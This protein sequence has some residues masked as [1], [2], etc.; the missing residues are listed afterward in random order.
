MFGGGSQFLELVPEPGLVP[1]DP[2]GP[3]VILQGTGFLD[4]AAELE[5]LGLV[6]PEVV[7]AGQHQVFFARGQ[8]SEELVEGDMAAAQ[9]DG[10]A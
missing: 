8:G 1:A 3:F 6:E 10:D 7:A 9:S 2:Q 5:E 4:Q